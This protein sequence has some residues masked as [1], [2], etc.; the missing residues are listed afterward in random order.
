MAPVKNLLDAVKSI[1]KNPGNWF[2]SAKV[3]PLAQ[4]AEG[5]VLDYKAM[6]ADRI[7]SKNTPG[8]I[9]DYSNFKNTKAGSLKEA[10]FK[11]AGLLVNPFVQGGLGLTG[12]LGAYGLY[13]HLNPP[14]MMDK[15]KEN[16]SDLMS[17]IDLNSIM[18]MLAYQDQG[19]LPQQN[20]QAM[21]QDM[22]MH[23]MQPQQQ[24][25]DMSQ[26]MPNQNFGALNPHWQ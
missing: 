10:A 11:H 5:G 14:T 17:G 22:N 21:P 12:L 8:S 13:K 16:A 6:R 9:I 24:L 2:N 7:G 20:P 1:G 25:P 3:A 4:K 23:A 19:M 15:I 18:P 26:Y